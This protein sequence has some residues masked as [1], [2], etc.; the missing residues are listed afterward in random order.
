M[1]REGA[2]PSALYFLR[3]SRREKRG[4]EK[5]RKKKNIARKASSLPLLLLAQSLGEKKRE[6]KRKKWSSRQTKKR[7][8]IGE[9]VVSPLPSNEM[10]LLA[11]TRG[12]EKK[13]RIRTGEWRKGRGETGRGGSPAL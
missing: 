2:R 1:G 6:K 9:Q 4:A 7:V 5:K 12:R 10:P 11:A 3:L 8:R 13:E